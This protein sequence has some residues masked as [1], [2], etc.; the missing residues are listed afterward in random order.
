M[1][2]YKNAPDCGTCGML[3]VA[4]K[5]LEIKETFIYFFLIIIILFLVYMNLCC[6][7]ESINNEEAL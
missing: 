1:L 7:L 2:K 5:R 4:F 3:I 6:A